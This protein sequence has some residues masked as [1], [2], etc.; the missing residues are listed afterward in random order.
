MGI[1]ERWQVDMRSIGLCVRDCL[2]VGWTLTLTVVLWLNSLDV[3]ELGHFHYCRYQCVCLCTVVQEVLR[4]S[5]TRVI[6]GQ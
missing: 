3:L 1:R 4:A 2:S 6:L 5:Q